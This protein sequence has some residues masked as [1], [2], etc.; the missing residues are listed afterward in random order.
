MR[1]MRGIEPLH[2]ATAERKHLAIGQRA[3]PAIGDVVDRHHRGDLATERHRHRRRRQKLVES[4]A[5]VGLDMR[6]RDIAQPLDRNGAGD[7]LADQREQLARA[8]VEQ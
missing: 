2:L 7:R 3:R 4:A 1:Q 5:F 6:Q 8:G